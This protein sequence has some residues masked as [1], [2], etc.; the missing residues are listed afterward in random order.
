LGSTI[1]KV[2]GRDAVTVSTGPFTLWIATALLAVVE[3]VSTEAAD[4][5]SF[6]GFISALSCTVAFVSLVDAIT[7]LA[8]PLV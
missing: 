4:V 3:A 8:L 6:I 5:V 1:T 2:S 7:V